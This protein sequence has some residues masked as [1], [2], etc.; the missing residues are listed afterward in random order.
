MTAVRKELRRRRRPIG[1]A[2]MLVAITAVL[3]FAL[4]S[5][6]TLGTSPFEIDPSTPSTLPG[7]NLKVD[8]QAPAIDWASAS[9]VEQR[10]EDL[11]SGSGDDSFGQG[12]K[13]D[14]PVPTVVSGSIP[15]QKSDLTH[16]SVALVEPAT[17]GRFLELFWRRVQE[18][19]GTTNMD[20][21]FNKSR[22]ISGNGKTPIRS[23]GD[24]LIQYDLSRGGTSP[25]LWLSRWVVSGPASQCEANNA[26][27]CWSTKVN[28]TAAGVAI[29]SINNQA[30]PAAESDGLGASSPRTFGEAE[31]DLNALSGGGGGGTCSVFGSAYL[32]SR[33]SDSFTSEIKDFIAPE[34][35][36]L[37]TCATVIIRKVTD[38]VTDPANLQ[39]GYT[40]SINTSPDTP[41]TF[42]LGHGEN[43][44]YSNV[45]I[46]NGYTVNETTLPTGW[47]FDHV[48]CSASVGVTVDTSA[49]PLITF[50]IDNK[51][52][53]VDCTY[54]N[55]ARGTIIVEKITDDGFGPF[56][57]T[58]ATLTPSPFTLTTTAP[59]A[60]GK[61]SRTFGNLIPGSYDVTETVP[62]GWNLVSFT[63]DD[64]ST[65]LAISVSAGETVTCTAHNARKRGAIDILKLRKHAASGPDDIP[66]AGVTFTVTGGGIPAPGIAVVT[67]ADG[68]ACVP[69]LLLSSFVGA[70]T[71]TETVPSGYHVV[72]TNPQVKSVTSEATCS[73]GSRPLAEFHNLPLTNV[74][75]EVDSQVPGGTASVIDCGP[76]GSGSTGADGD[77]F[78]AIPNKEPSVVTC[79]ITIDP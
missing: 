37:D 53:V 72:S 43:K 63:C 49:A 30:I 79:T 6:A 59:G 32:K 7:A 65:P 34:N 24:A 41:N 47:D 29:G 67:D 46:G 60:A 22:T 38:P 26:I 11:A 33:S 19:N 5:S 8:G 35:V 9:V 31:V 52:D 18:P 77:G 42:T 78:L 70:Y 62:A 50:S 10:K 16:F 12:T 55:K 48:D 54:T 25:T 3:V 75:V 17:G 27:P 45:L 28:M 58:S 13:E 21:E 20:F 4:G 23:E 14:T 64:G 73:T 44:T 56:D 1:L 15:P 2:A 51:D 36:D 68:E 71:V 66:H 39:F 57:F 69:G 74:R 76:D 61:D 40:K